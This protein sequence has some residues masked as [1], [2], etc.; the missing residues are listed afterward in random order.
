MREGK[1]MK[2]K[3]HLKSGPVEEEEEGEHDEREKIRFHNNTIS[4]AGMCR[5]YGFHLGISPDY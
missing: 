5:V 2:W 3:I 4:D 1:F